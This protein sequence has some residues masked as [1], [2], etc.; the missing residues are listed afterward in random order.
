MRL[1][2]FSILLTVLLAFVA[3]DPSGNKEKLSLEFDS[4]AA[5][6]KNEYA[7]DRREKTFEVELEFPEGSDIPVV[8]GVTTEAGAKEALFATLQERGVDVKDSVVILPHPDLGEKTYGVTAQSVINFRY[9]ARYSSESATQC[10]MGMP[11][12]LLEKRGNWTRAITPEGYIA[13]V[14]SGSVQPMNKE[15]Y[16]EWKESRKLIVTTHYTLFRES[17]LDNAAVVSDGVWGNVVQAKRR[18]GRYYQVIL[19]N[20]KEAYVLNSDVEEFSSWL[21][22]RNPTPENIIA[23]AKEFVGFPYMWGG[24]S[25]KA[26]DCSGFTKTSF[27]LNGIILER[28]ASQQA[29]TGVDV[30][31]TEGL[32][33]LEPGDLLFFGSKATEERPERVTHVGIYIGEGV[34]IHSAT[35]VKINSLLPD[36]PDYYT[37]STRLV[38]ARRVH[39]EAD[40]DPDIVSI[41]NHPWYF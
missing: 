23:T 21:D 26:M 13:W 6:V 1:R 14:S 12:R 3:C 24:T 28:D 27:F 11:L 16:Y 22:S 33:N 34:F 20:G 10:L 15:E 38:R 32:D 30:D 9:G 2:N 36:A 41:K 37:G 29:K 19:P 31:I 8:Y 40:K 5:D 25:I 17:P 4:V 35:S 18:A 39:T 7:P